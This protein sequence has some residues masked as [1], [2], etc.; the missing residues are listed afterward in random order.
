[1]RKKSTNIGKRYRYVFTLIELLVVVAIIA[2]LASMLLPALNSAIIKARG[3]ECVSRMKTIGNAILLYAGDWDDWIIP[4]K[5]STAGVGTVWIFVLSD[6]RYGGLRWHGD[7]P[8]YTSVSPWACPS[9]T[10]SFG[11]YRDDPPHFQYGHYA[12]NRWLSGSFSMPVNRWRRYNNVA[13]PS[14]AIMVTDNQGKDGCTITRTQGV[15]YRHGRRPDPRIA[16]LNPG[17]KNNLIAPPSDCVGNFLYC[18]GHVSPRSF[19]TIYNH[20][21]DRWSD[22]SDGGTRALLCGF[23]RNSG[24]A[25]DS[26]F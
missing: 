17:D 13:Q 20:T 7:S 22:G 4:A 6:G 18:D 24:V 26:N 8:K 12:I 23:N 3:I 11:K 16:I 15:A 1:M 5:Q 2:I 14:G 10:V 19:D 9:E 25:C 21:K